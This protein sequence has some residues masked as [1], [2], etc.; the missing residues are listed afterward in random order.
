MGVVPE[1]RRS[2]IGH[3]GLPR[4][5][6]PLEVLRE[7]LARLTP[8]VPE[9][10][11]LPRFVGGAVGAISYD[12]VRFVEQLPDENPDPIGMPELWFSLPETVVVYDNVRH[13]ALIVRQVEV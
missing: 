9:D 5:R 2:P 1:R 6:D 13:S 11:S 3:E 7:R 4:R 8:A 12:W 10:M